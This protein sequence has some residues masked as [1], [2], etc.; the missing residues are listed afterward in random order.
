MAFTTKDGADDYN[1]AKEMVDIFAKDIL[2]YNDGLDGLTFEEFYE[3]LTLDIA[4]T[5]KI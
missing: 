1:L 3:T 4:T 2:K 5:G